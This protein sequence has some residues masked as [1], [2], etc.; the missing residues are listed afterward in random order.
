MELLTCCTLVVVAW[1]VD[2][3]GELL[4][5]VVQVV[6]QERLTCKRAKKRKMEKG[7]VSSPLVS[8]KTC[9]ITCKPLLSL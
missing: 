8:I 5:G 3:D 6:D 9:I 2:L 4:F 7:C 1:T